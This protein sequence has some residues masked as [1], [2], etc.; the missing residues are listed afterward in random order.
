[1]RYRFLVIALMLFSFKAKS[2]SV[3]VTDEG[4]IRGYDPV[5]YFLEAAPIKGSPDFTF[6]WQGATWYFKSAGHRNMFIGDPERYAPQFGGFC[7]FGVSRNYKVKTEPDAW[8]IV[9]GKL[10]LN[11]DIQVQKKWLA[12]KHAYIVRAKSN[13][14]TLENSK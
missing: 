13:W 11:Y 10:Y 9:D 12:D 2:Q 14:V 6:T 1:M 8:S 5:A 7:S 4:A 3:F